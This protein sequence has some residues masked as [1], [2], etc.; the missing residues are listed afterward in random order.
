MFEHARDHEAIY[1]VLFN[2]AKGRRRITERLAQ[3]I[4]QHLAQ[5]VSRGD[6][7]EIPVE[8]AANH[9]A[10]SLLALIEWWLTHNQP[11]PPEDMARYYARMIVA[12]V[13]PDSTENHP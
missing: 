8:M 3:L 9:M 5:H 2:A 7:I 13:L 11:Y 4:Q 1:R 6:E 12:P 10:A